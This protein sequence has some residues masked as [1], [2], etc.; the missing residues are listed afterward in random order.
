MLPEG[1]WDV[2]LSS[3]FNVTMYSINISTNAT[4]NITIDGVPNANV[5]LTGF[6]PLQIVAMESGINFSNAT[7]TVPNSSITTSLNITVLACHTWNITNR[8]CSGSWVNTT[9]NSSITSGLATINTSN[10]S[11]FAV[12]R[13]TTCGDGVV[14]SGETS[15]TCCQD[16]GCPSGQI[17]NTDTRA[18]YTPSSGSFITGGGSATASKKKSLVI[19]TAPAS[20]SS[21]KGVE[22]SFIISLTD[23]GETNF[24]GVKLEIISD[25]ASCAFSYFNGNIDINT[26]QKK[27]Y[28][29]SVTANTSGTYSA[30]VKA[31]SGATNSTSLALVVTEC[32]PGAA[33]CSG[34]D[35]LTC[36]Q[37]GSRVGTTSCENGC[38]GGRCLNPPASNATEGN[39]TTTEKQ[40]PELD[41]TFAAGVIIAF[42]VVAVALIIVF[43]KL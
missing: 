12:M 33:K 36:S 30:T 43:L 14:E 41:P 15:S 16:A 39:K 22:K 34:S 9:I 27:D 5:S 4:G 35:L 13:N 8:S 20:L 10:F 26:G 38:S 28:T 6:V 37:D 31:I 21:V 29:A 3:T 40:S 32:E 23:S 24:T 19:S 7:I 2:R 17:C 1:I 42:S 11:A 25:C 18:C